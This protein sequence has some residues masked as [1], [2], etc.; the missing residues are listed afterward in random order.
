MCRA[1]NAED[2]PALP[3]VPESGLQGAAPDVAAPVRWHELTPDAQNRAYEDFL[4]SGNKDTR[5]G[6]NNL[7]RKGTI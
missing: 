2:V 1:V 6:F 3:V 5:E 7:T 4:S